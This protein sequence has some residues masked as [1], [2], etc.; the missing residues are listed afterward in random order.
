M[1]KALKH[2]YVVLLAGG[3]GTRL[4]PTS[5]SQTPKQF[6]KLFGRHT[7]FQETIRRVKGLVPLSRVFVITNK[8]Y[9]DEIEQQEPLL[10]EKNII[11]EPVKRNTALAM[12]VAAAYVYKK[13]P[14]AVI[15]NLAT[16]HLITE[17]DV[18]R[19]TLAT[20]AAFAQEHRCL[21][22]VGIVPTFPH[23]GLGYIQSGEKVGKVGPHDVFKVKSFK[24]KPDEDTA[25]KFL[26]EGGYF[27][28]ANNYVWHAATVL[29]E[30]KTLCPDIFKNI[31]AIYEAIGTPKE[32]EVLNEQYHAA[33]EE[34]IDTAISE[35]TDKLYVIPGSFGWDDVGDWKVV[36]D[37]SSKDADGNHVAVH[38][39]QGL[40]LG[41]DTKNSLIHTA[42]KLVATIGVDNLIIIETKDALLVCHKDQAQ[43]VKQL[44]GLI[45]DKKLKRYL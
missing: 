21:V 6:N 17:N 45:K 43:T 23:T 14:D 4:W 34:Q 22:S 35:K 12:G 26:K 10:V 39:Q 41:I 11:A 38:G 20:A 32:A 3:A 44:V 30:F 8:D 15:I 9:L 42:D 24:E 1:E 28:N 37:L 33:R 19:D 7:L 31:M 40:H 29:N 5:R 25:K 13:D 2:T 18:Y 36:Y 16:D 27:W